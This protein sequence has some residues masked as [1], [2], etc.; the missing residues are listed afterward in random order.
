MQ[1]ER[2]GLRPGRLDYRVA[3]PVLV[4]VLAEAGE[5]RPG[6]PLELGRVAGR[7]PER[8]VDV[9]ADD[10]LGR[11]AAERRRDD[12]AAVAALRAVPR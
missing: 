5:F 12:R 3:G 1:S 6:Q 9:Y 10:V 8:A 2:E 4:L 11:D 7:E